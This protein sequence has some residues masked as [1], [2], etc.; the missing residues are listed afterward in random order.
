[1]SNDNTNPPTDDTIRKLLSDIQTAFAI[2]ETNEALR[3]ENIRLKAQVEKQSWREFNL[4]IMLGK[5]QVILDDYPT[6]LKVLS[7]GELYTFEG[8]ASTV[9][10]GDTVL[11]ISRQSD[12]LE[13]EIAYIEALP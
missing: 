4:Q 8:D 1:M 12:S 2:R 5:V 10:K 9:E 7:Q 3:L 11:I 6:T 13:N